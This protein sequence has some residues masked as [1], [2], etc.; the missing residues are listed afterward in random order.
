MLKDS[1]SEI[2]KDIMNIIENNENFDN[3]IKEKVDKL[4]KKQNYV[5][6][7]D[8]E[9]YY[10]PVEP[11]AGTTSTETLTGISSTVMVS[12][13]TGDVIVINPSTN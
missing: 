12:N 13:D 2:S 5:Y 6:E 9:I 3:I 11:P 1:E 7:K 4:D 10:G 8:G